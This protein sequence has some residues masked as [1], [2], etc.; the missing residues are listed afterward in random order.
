MA[1]HGQTREGTEVPR[2]CQR[3][4]WCSRPRSH[5][6][7]LPALR[8]MGHPEGHQRTVD[9]SARREACVVHPPTRAVPEDGGEEGGGL[10]TDLSEH[11]SMR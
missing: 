4:T 7:R 3:L 10:G 6:G 1:Q 9:G 2:A 11:T 8:L 5:H